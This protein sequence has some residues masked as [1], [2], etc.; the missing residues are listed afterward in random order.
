MHVTTYSIR[1][2]FRRQSLVSESAS[3]VDGGDVKDRLP[4]TTQSFKENNE[5]AE[6]GPKVTMVSDASIL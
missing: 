3:K 5:G 1:F 6:R 4:R 2:Q